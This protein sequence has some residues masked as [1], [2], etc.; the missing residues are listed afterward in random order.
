MEMLSVYGPV[1][2][3]DA[4]FCAQILRRSDETPELLIAAGDWNW[5][6]SYTKAMTSNWL[7]VPSGPTVLRSNTRPT[8][9]ITTGSSNH[10]ATTKTVLGIPHHKAVVYT[11]NK[12]AAPPRQKSR[13]QHCVKFIWTTPPDDD[14]C[15]ILKRAAD[16]AGPPLT[17]GCEDLEEAWG[18]F[19]ILTPFS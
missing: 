18:R 11:V 4:Q 10:G 13:L 1:H 15:E 16:S 9:C 8:R 3:P 14:Q 7:A 12:Q 5:K 2:K 19:Q 6:Q 17:E